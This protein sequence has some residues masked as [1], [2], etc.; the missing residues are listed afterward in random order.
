MTSVLLS[1]AVWLGRRLLQPAY[2]ATLAS[3]IIQIATGLVM[4]GA[5]RGDSYPFSPSGSLALS[6]CGKLF[7]STISFFQECRKRFAADIL[8][9][10]VHHGAGYATL[11][12]SN[13]PI[14]ARSGVEEAERKRP[15]TSTQG[16]SSPN[17]IGLSGSMGDSS[18]SL[19]LRMFWGYLQE[20]V[21][22]DLRWGFSYLALLYVL[23]NNLVHL[24]FKKLLTQLTISRYSSAIKSLILLRYN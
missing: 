17:A 5:Q 3:V 13:L 1:I 22:T 6:E 21:S 14:S 4:K 19:G 2:M 12:E 9:P 23:V 7:F 8:P 11:S 10:P 15:G 20:E 18:P 16:P 24:T